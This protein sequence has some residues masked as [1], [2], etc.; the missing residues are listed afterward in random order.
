MAAFRLPDK[1]N[2]NTTLIDI[3]MEGIYGL[4]AVY[5][6]RGVRTCLIDAGTRTDAP[7]LVRLLKELDAFPP[8]LIVVSHPHWDHAQGIPFLRQE[9][10]RQGR[11]IEVMASSEAIPL[12]AAKADSL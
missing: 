5:L 12:L 4:T 6:I 8:N 10:L 2:E 7:R 11:K 3:G 1:I 9:A